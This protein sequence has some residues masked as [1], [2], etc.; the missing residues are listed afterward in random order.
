MIMKEKGCAAAF[1]F[2]SGVKFAIIDIESKT[3]VWKR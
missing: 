1:F 3:Q 2:I